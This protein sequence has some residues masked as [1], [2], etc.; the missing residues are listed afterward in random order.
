MSLPTTYDEFASLRPSEKANFFVDPD[1]VLQSLVFTQQTDLAWYKRLH[2]LARVIQKNYDSPD[3]RAFLCSVLSGYSAVLYF[4]QPSTRTFTSFSLAAQGLG[5]VVEEIRDPNMSSLYKGESGLDSLLTLAELSDLI[6]MR[7]D[8]E[9]LI[10]EFAYEVRRRGVSTRIINGGNGSDQHPTQALLDLYT[11]SSHIGLDKFLKHGYTVN[12]MGDL[13]HS[14]T[15][16]SLSYLL[17]MFPNVA[18]RFVA[19][20]M[21]Q[22]NKDILQHLDST[23]ILYECTDDY[24]KAYIGDVLYVVRMQDEYHKEKGLSYST[25]PK[26]FKV[27]PS[28]LKRM[29]EGAIVLHPLPRRDE[30]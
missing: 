18:Q 14:R 27:D 21:F 22:V 30:K 19:P 25:D 3:F 11:I 12:M 10:D 17:S 24:E 15:V 20:E 9:V 2:K 8:S 4:N 6:I 1:G 7:Q 23:G 5:M 13:K 28:S 26:A 16:R 29:N